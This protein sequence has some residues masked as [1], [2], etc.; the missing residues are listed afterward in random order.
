M[1]LF[2]I[3]SF[4]LIWIHR[5]WMHNL[6]SLQLDLLEQNNKFDPTILEANVFL[7]LMLFVLMQIEVFALIQI[8]F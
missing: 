2:G 3:D 7:R 6:R 4:D 1:L 5:N 8:F